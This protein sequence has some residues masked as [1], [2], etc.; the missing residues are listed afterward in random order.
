M[1]R[2]FQSVTINAERDA[3][4]DLISRVEEF[5]LYAHALREVEQIGRR[6]YRWV[7]NVR[8][9]R[10]GWDSKITEFRRPERIAWRSIK[11]FEN[12]GA[13]TLIKVAGGTRVELRID[14]RFP[15][16]PLGRLMEGLVAPVTRA[17]AAAILERVRRRLEEPSAA[18]AAKAAPRGVKGDGRMAASRPRRQYADRAEYSRSDHGPRPPRL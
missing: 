13:Y 7:A 2:I 14:Y 6:T 8:G 17:A 10:L 15:G 16:G 5:P 12:A 4:F 11:G 3:V 1:A 18:I 9:L